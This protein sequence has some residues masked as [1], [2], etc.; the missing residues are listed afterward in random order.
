MAISSAKS[1]PGRHSSTSLTRKVKASHSYSTA[2]TRLLRTVWGV[3][4][5]RK[6]LQDPIF[7]PESLRNE[8]KALGVTVFKKKK[9]RL[10]VIRLILICFQR[11]FFPMKR[12]TQNINCIYYFTF[13]LNSHGRGATH[14]F[15]PHKAIYYFYSSGFLLLFVCFTS[16]D[17][18]IQLSYFFFFLKS[19]SVIPNSNTIYGHTQAHAISK[20]SM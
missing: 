12:E 8:R 18:R 5:G 11:T 20:I 17:G 1:W 10:Q 13:K 19:R 9:K 2:T 15:R 4:R 3:H 7:G 16:H 14:N 6:V